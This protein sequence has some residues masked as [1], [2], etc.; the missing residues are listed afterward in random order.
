ML[1]ISG[2]PAFFR[3]SS[4]STRI[5]LSSFICSWAAWEIIRSCSRTVSPDGSLRDTPFSYW[6]HKPATRTIKNSSK[7]E[8][9]M[10]INFNRSRIGVV[11]TSASRS[12]RRLNFSQLSSRLKKYSGRFK[13]SIVTFLSL[14]ASAPLPC[15]GSETPALLILFFTTA[16]ALFT[17]AGAFFSAATVLFP[18]FVP[19]FFFISLIMIPPVPILL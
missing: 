3:S 14:T 18:V 11:S 10:A 2:P 13:S 8:D 7:L 17:A 12:T 16:A 1:L 9:V 5:L 19:V 15:A 6:S 4:T